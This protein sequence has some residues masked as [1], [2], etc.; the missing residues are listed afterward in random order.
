[1]I[2]IK[3]ICCSFK[4]A[5]DGFVYA[6]RTQNNLRIHHLC[7][8]IVIFLAW[9]LD[10]SKLDWIILIFSIAI[11]LFAELMN[12]AIE[13]ICDI[14]EPN[15]NINVKR[16]KDIAASS[17]FVTVCSAVVIGMITFYPYLF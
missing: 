9:M 17:V 16:A 7:A 1:M 3:K 12:T 2:F 13:Y 5:F 6:L 10:V 4:Y 14:I 11:V 8:L 15:Y